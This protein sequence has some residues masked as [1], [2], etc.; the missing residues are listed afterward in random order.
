M[1][2]SISLANTPQSEVT[3][4]LELLGSMGVKPK[5]LSR[6]RNEDS[7]KTARRVA[8]I[9]MGWTFPD[10]IHWKEA[11]K[12]M[13]K[14]FFGP[15]EWK[16]YFNVQFTPEQMEQVTEFPW[17]LEAL[18]HRF[19]D[20]VPLRHKDYFAFL[21]ISEING[22]P[23]TIAQW[24]EL[25]RTV[26]N[27]LPFDSATSG[28]A[29][30]LGIDG[31]Y[32]NYRVPEYENCLTKKTCSFQWYFMHLKGMGIS[33]SSA[34]DKDSFVS[35]AIERLT[36]LFL[37]SRRHGKPYLGPRVVCSD[38]FGVN[39]DNLEGYDC[40]VVLS[41]ER[42]VSLAITGHSSNGEQVHRSVCRIPGL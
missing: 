29:S 5:H 18:N 39:S 37:Y 10:S 28:L 26:P 38:R 41:G 24:V 2:R 23:L 30:W 25:S 20:S 34:K 3:S 19:V 17:S 21:G 32:S 33:C 35:S 7:R 27:V 42:G 1:S 14:N 11:K 36:M 4:T 15:A 22:Q 16:R 8:N 6:L 13:G 9:A 40:P 31:S 12:I